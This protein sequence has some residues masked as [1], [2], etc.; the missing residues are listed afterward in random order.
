MNKRRL[1]HFWT[2]LRLVKPWYFLILAIVSGVICL[3][4]LRSNYQHT[5]T[6]KNAVYQA[7][8]DNGDYKTA[9]QNLRNYVIAHMN[10]SLTTGSNSIY[11]PIQL[12]YTY[13]RLTQQAVQASSN[14]QLY[15][16]AQA[17]CQQQD[18]TD[19]SGRNRVPCIEAYVTSHGAKPAA[20]V[21][22]NLYQFDFVSPTWSP[23]LAGWS[24][25]VTALSLVLFIGL[26]LAERVIRKRVE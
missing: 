10:T 22:V 3:A 9:L 6:L 5:V 14:D 23:D 4:A 11:P 13:E 7:D 2:R 17:Y 26:W 19:F 12:K 18:P 15:T 21:P 8:K 1:H 16:A 20:A 24:M 25:V